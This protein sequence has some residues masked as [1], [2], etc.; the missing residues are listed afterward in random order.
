[1]V[2]FEA[3]FFVVKNWMVIQMQVILNSEDQL[4]QS[5]QKTPIALVTFPLNMSVFKKEGG[6]LI[7][8]Q[9]EWIMRNTTHEIVS[10]ID[11]VAELV[12]GRFVKDIHHN[13]PKIFFGRI[14]V[15][16]SNV[17]V[18]SRNGVFSRYLT[19]GQ[20]LKVVSILKIN[21]TSF[22]GINEREIISSTTKGI[23]YLPI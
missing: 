11:G 23:R 6:E 15:I 8:I 9:N 22:F 13:K 7:R 4:N 21:T 2:V 12:D 20:V 10:I 5:E 16:E 3:G 17:P 19:K 18:F 1:M 14:E